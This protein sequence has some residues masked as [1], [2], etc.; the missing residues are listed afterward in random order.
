M[1]ISDDI[2]AHFTDLR[3]KRAYRYLIIAINDE[4]NAASIEHAGA[5]TDDFAAFKAKMPADAPRYAVYDLE[6]KTNDGRMESK[7][8]FVM[9]SPD[10]CANGQ[11]R[12]VYAQSKDGIKQKL[13]PVHKEL[14]INDPSD[15]N[16]AEFISE[17]N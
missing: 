5:R 15:L 11:S 7:V 1:Q 8:V 9:Y 13:N 16:E 12:F 14:Q 17:F 4:G 2:A 10:N 3:M 6:F